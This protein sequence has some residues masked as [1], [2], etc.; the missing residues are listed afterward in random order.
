MPG[1]FE[2]IRRHFTRVRDAAAS[3]VLLGVG[4][5]AALLAPSPG[6]ALA[7]SS[8][9]LVNGVHFPADTPAADIGWKALAVNLSDLAAMGAAPRAAL[10]ALTLP[11]ADDAWCAE[12]ARGLFM[13]ADQAGCPLIGGDTT[14]GP[15]SITVT[16]LGEVPVDQALRRR[17][18]RPGDLVCVSGFPGEAALGLGRWRGGSRDVA[19][20]AIARLLRPSPRLTLGLALRGVATACID[21]SDG[22]L[23]DLAHVLAASAVDGVAGADIDLAALPRS[24]V[25]AALSDDTALDCVLAGGDDYEL[26]FTVPATA[27]ERLPRIAAETGVPL[28]VIGR[29]TAGGGLRCLDTRGQVRPVTRRSWEHFNGR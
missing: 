25:L 3:G 9:T 29:V 19:D 18:A 11:A 17:G 10:L 26:C 23:G 14:S 4:D 2:L 15:L 16:V 6:M 13:L 1:E 20:P 12:F 22:L 7:A 24:P 28:T 27:H 8:D 5:D 21:V